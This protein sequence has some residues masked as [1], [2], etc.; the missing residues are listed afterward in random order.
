[1]STTPSPRFPL[2]TPPV[3][4][5]FVPGWQLNHPPPAPATNAP[6]QHSETLQ[7]PRTATFPS[8]MAVAIDALSITFSRLS[9]A[10]SIDVRTAPPSARFLDQ[11]PPPSPASRAPGAGKPRQP[12]F[13]APSCSSVG[14]GRGAV[15]PPPGFPSVVSP[16]ERLARLRAAQRLLLTPTLS[17]QHLSYPNSP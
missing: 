9:L 1:M 7:P 3:T 2:Q 13:L 17:S 8:D 15:T 12:L 6:P 10:D 14:E 16:A 4:D 5:P 11:T